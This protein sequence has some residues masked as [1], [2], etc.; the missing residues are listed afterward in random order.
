MR[1]SDASIYIAQFFVLFNI[2]LG[3]CD[4]NHALYRLILDIQYL[5]SSIDPLKANFTRQPA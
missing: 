2:V 1:S 3:I 4:E 5:V